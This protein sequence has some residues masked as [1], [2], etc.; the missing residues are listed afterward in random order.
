M[1][2]SKLHDE[3]C[4]IYRHENRSVMAIQVIVAVVK[5]HFGK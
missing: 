4:L 1:P 5:K 3:I 2:V